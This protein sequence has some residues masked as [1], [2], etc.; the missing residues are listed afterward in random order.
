MMHN[1]HTIQQTLKIVEGYYQERYDQVTRLRG[2]LAL[3]EW[4]P[5]RDGNES[6]CPVCNST[7]REGHVEGCLLASM[8]REE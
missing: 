6:V 7:K 1:P 5:E 3:F 4:S 8:L 2:M